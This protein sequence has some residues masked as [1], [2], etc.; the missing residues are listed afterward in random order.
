MC[1]RLRNWLGENLSKVLTSEWVTAV[2]RDEVVEAV[3][4]LLLNEIE[5]GLA[6]DLHRTYPT[7]IDG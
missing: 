5:L 7:V 6:A 2:V 3:K 1:I 4:R